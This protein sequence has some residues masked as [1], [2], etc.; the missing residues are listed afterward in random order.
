MRGILLELMERRHGEISTVFRTQYTQKDWHQRLGPGIH[1]NA[2]MDRII[3]SRIWVETDTY[4]M[5]E[6]AGLA[7]AQRRPQRRASGLQSHCQRLLLARSLALNRTIGWLSRPQIFRQ[8]QLGSTH[9]TNL[10]VQRRSTKVSGAGVC[11]SGRVSSRNRDT[12]RMGVRY[13]SF[14]RNG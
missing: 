7:T 13:T 8:D 5:R 11:V 3:H 12:G 6:Q 2:I 14:A 4:D 10:A 9:T 1:A